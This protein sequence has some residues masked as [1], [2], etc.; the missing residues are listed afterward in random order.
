MSRTEPMIW[1]RQGVATVRH[2]AG[3]RRHAAAL[4]LGMRWYD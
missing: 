4:H 3:A 1:E 2:R